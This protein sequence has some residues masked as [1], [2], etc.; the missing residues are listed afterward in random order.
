MLRNARSGNYTCTGSNSRGS[1]SVSTTIT[2]ESGESYDTVMRLLYN[3]LYTD[4]HI[5]V[6][7]L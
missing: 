2:V 3:V 6:R 4:H 5:S 7:V 1:L